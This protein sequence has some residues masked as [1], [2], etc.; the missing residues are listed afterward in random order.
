MP[1]KEEGTFLWMNVQDGGMDVD[2]A[3]E[4]DN[5]RPAPRREAIEFEWMKGKEGG[6]DQR[7]ISLLLK[8]PNE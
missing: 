1:Q 4:W 2:Y 8:D 7:G 3:R 5:P 6:S